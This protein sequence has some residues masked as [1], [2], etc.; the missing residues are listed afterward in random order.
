MRWHDQRGGIIGSWLLQLVLLMAVLGVVG[1]E[2]VSVGV[3]TVSTDD[4]ARQVARAARDEYRAHLSLGRAIEVADE[5]ATTH[6]AQLLTV[7]Q[8]GND[9]VVTVQRQAPTLLTHR[10]GP[11]QDLTVVRASGRSGRTP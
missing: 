1:Y 10:I 11:L 6:G 5:V 3:A 4:T 2:I 7:E 9:L 8:D